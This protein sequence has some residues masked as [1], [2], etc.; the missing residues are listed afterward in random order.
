MLPCVNVLEYPAAAWSRHNRFIVKMCPAHTT[1]PS[2]EF[3]RA[4]GEGILCRTLCDAG[5]NMNANPMTMKMPS[6]QPEL[7]VTT[8]FLKPTFGITVQSHTL[9]VSVEA[10]PES[11]RPPA[12]GPARG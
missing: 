6:S 4:T 8:L 9:S 2:Q 7:P 5:G 10:R 1:T 3:D 12:R 11:V